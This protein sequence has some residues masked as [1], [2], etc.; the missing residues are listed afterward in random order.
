M[1]DVRDLPALNAALNS[2]AAILLVTAWVLIRRR[3]PIAHRNVM[4][5]ALVCSTL[6]L[7]SYLIYHFQVRSVPFQGTGPVRALYFTILLTHTILAA[8]VPFLAGITVWR[9]YRRRYD[10]HVRIARWTLPIWLYVSVT[11]VVIYWML[12]QMTW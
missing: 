1:L 12:Y 2:L 5:A 6:F 11:G 3:R 9:A 7:T 4:I 10:R 8:C